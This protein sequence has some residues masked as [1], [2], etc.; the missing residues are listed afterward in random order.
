[1]KNL[2]KIKDWLT[3]F[4]WEYFLIGFLMAFFIGYI[5]TGIIQ[6]CSVL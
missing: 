4:E 5:I 3:P 2:K 6:T 1:M